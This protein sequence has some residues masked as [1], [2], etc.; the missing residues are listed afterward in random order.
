MKWEYENSEQ[1]KTNRK[2]TNDNRKDK[3]YQYGVISLNRGSRRDWQRNNTEKLKRY[4]LKRKLKEHE[5][6]NEE[7]ESCKNYF[8]YRCAYCNLAIEE[9]WVKY[10]GKIILGDFHREHVDDEGANDLSNCIPSCKSC[11]TGK[12]DKKFEEW[13]NE[14]NKNYTVERYKKILNWLVQDFKIYIKDVK[15][16][17]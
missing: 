3:I 8:N 7:W 2:R 14:T 16:S 11:N 13:Y 12:H 6:T 1:L 17:G 5:I 15:Q 4:S 9:H 10:S